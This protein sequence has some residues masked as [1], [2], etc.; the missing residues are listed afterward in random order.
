MSRR[1]LLVLSRRR[2]SQ[3][4][5]AVR[6][7]ATGSGDSELRMKCRGDV[8]N[9]KAEAGAKGGVQ[10]GGRQLGELSCGGSGGEEA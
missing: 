1:R 5:Y 9:G 3:S 4:G 6:Y 2:L 8:A 7:S 10:A